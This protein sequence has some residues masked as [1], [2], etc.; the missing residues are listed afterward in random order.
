MAKIIFFQA[1]PDDLE[2]SC[3][4][5]M[6]YLAKKSK[7]NHVIRVA[8][9]TKGEFGLPGAEYD[10]FKGDFLA[11][12]RTRELYMAQAIHGIPPE[13]ID[14]FGYIDGFVKFNREFIKRITDYI[15]KEKPDIII[16]PEPIYTWYF[17]KDHINTGKAIFYIIYNKLIDYEK[18]PILY[19]YSSLSSN[20]YFGFRKKEIALTKKLISKHK[21]QAWLMN[22][23]MMSYIP[24][25]RLAGMKLKRWKYAEAYR[26]IYI[27]NPRKHKP[28]LLSRMISHFCYSH[29][30]WYSAK[31]PQA[32]LE[33][34]KRKGE[35]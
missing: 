31:Y 2:L 29:I 9:M 10:K 1:H 24:L 17:H 32:I 3:C 18:T 25:T 35:I 7:K 6:H 28:S 30:Q 14:F 20:Y 15:N 11:K 4:H 21:T 5:L 8:S 16:A 12:V 26:R 33:D 23:L 34:L 22:T 13:N 19:Y 27:K